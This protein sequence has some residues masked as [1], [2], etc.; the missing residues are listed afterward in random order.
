MTKLN[1]YGDARNTVIGGQFGV[2]IALQRSD[3]L[4]NMAILQAYNQPGARALDAAS[5]G[6]GQAFRLAQAGAD[7]LAF[8]IEDYSIPFM[9]ATKRNDVS[10]RCR[11]LQCDLRDYDIS[12]KHDPFNI[13][14]CQRMMHYVPF[15]TALN[16]VAGFRN[17]LSEGG[18][19]YISA[20]GISSELGQG[21]AHKELPV[22]S[23]YI[24]LAPPMV[25]KHAIYGP[26]CLYSKS[27][28]EQ[29]L[30]RIGF[31]VVSIFT[32][33]FGN[34]KAVATR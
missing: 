1:L 11:F 18:N 8:D 26:V 2:D 20:S 30:K 17:A 24:E 28:M 23:R 13:I 31:K 9:E 32:S 27:D 16:I 4:D 14:V 5:A 33:P 7:T 12:K 6:G 21:Y 10:K 29:L 15:N 25:D 19:L 3:D 22:E 34:V